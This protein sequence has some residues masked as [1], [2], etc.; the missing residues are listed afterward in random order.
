V[1]CSI[2][3]Y[4]DNYQYYSRLFSDVGPFPLGGSSIPIYGFDLTHFW[5]SYFGMITYKLI[6]KKVKLDSTSMIGGFLATLPTFSWLIE[7]T[8]V[9]DNGRKWSTILH[10]ASGYLNTEFF[11][12]NKKLPAIVESL[13]FL[14]NTNKITISYDFSEVFLYFR[15]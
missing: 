11:I 4:V 9:H 10:Y 12:F 7:S 2:Y 1:P 15:F 6:K 3:L 14:C 8:L 5:A 13:I